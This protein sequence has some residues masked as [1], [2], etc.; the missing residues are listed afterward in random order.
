MTPTIS[1]KVANWTCLKV[2]TEKLLCDVT[3]HVIITHKLYFVNIHVQIAA[4][5]RVTVMAR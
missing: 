5:A 1:V 3:G 4:R 2:I